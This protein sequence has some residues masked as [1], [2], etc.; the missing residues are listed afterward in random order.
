M[1]LINQHIRQHFKN[2]NGGDT[3][4]FNEIYNL[5]QS[6]FEDNYRE[7]LKHLD[8]LLNVN[9][10]NKKAKYFIFTFSGP[11]GRMSEFVGTIPLN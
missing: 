11:R 6:D 2:F 10:K 7:L 5:I 3:V 8:H 9:S 4:Q 1:K